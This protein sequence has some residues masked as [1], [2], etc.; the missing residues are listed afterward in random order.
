M[1]SLC[2]K[3]FERSDHRRVYVIGKTPE[4]DETIEITKCGDLIVFA[5]G[6]VE[7]FAATLKEM[8]ERYKNSDVK[9]EVDDILPNINEFNYGNA[10]HVSL[11]YD[12]YHFLMP[13]MSILAR[14]GWRW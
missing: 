14:E 3:L 13:L 10:L 5:C 9:Y 2:S 4:E 12:G 7:L 8:L 1:S 6:G 11:M